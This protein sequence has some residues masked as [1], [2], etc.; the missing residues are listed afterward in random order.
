MEKPINELRTESLSRYYREGKVKEKV[1]Q[2][3]E[4]G[5]KDQELDGVRPGD[6]KEEEPTARHTT[7][8][9]WVEEKYLDSLFPSVS[10]SLPALDH[11]ASSQLTRS[12]GNT[13]PARVGW[14]GEGHRAPGQTQEDCITSINKSPST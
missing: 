9:E 14:R 10:S 12:L 5:I 7:E 6:R 3:P 4:A 11:V 1:L 8:T 13:V 2:E